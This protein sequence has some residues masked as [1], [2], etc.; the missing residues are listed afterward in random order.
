MHS[1]H[2]HREHRAALAGLLTEPLWKAQR[3]SPVLEWWQWLCWTLQASPLG[4]WRLPRTWRDSTCYLLLMGVKCTDPRL[5]AVSVQALGIHLGLFGKGSHGWAGPWG[6]MSLPVLCW[7]LLMGRVALN[8]LKFKSSGLLINKKSIEAKRYFTRDHKPAILSVLS[9]MFLYFSSF[10]FWL[11]VD[12]TWS[13]LCSFPEQ[14]LREALH[15]F[16]W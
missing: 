7:V 5:A 4:L 11:W 2:C 6:W 14:Q 8:V 9:T 10:W 12:S 1:H 16:V 13:E 3:V 15:V